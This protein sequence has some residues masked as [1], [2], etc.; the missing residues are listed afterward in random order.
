MNLTVFCT[1]GLYS[2]SLRERGKNRPTKNQR[3][4]ALARVRLLLKH[5]IERAPPGKAPIGLCMLSERDDQRRLDPGIGRQA[6][7]SLEENLRCQRRVM[8]AGHDA[9]DVPGTDEGPRVVSGQ[10]RL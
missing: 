9:V 3:D 2:L 5:K 7:I 4:N 8:R 1:S 6:F 10:D